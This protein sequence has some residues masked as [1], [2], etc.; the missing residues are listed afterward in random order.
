MKRL[1]AAAV[2]IALVGSAG[3]AWAAEPLVDVAWVKANLGKPNIVL[4]DLRWP[5]S[6]AEYLR[7]H[8]PGAV[9][10]DYAKDG[11]RTKDKNGTIAMLPEPAALEK[12]IGG[13]GI[14]NNTRIVLVPKGGNSLDVGAATR[15]YWTFKVLGHDNVSILDGGWLAWAVEDEK[16]KNPIN[17]MEG[18]NIEPKAKT[19]KANVRTDM[20]P[21]K[22]DVKKALATKTLLV[23]NRPN[24]Y[25]IGVTHHPDT[26]QP[27]TIPGAKNLPEAWLTKD[28]RG[29]FRTKAEL[30]KLYAAAGVPTNGEQ[31]NFC[32]TGHW[33]SVGWFA[34]SEILGNKKAKMYDGSMVEWSADPT[35]PMEKKVDLAK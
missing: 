1:F 32:N 17:P 35:A 23:D 15:V 9:Y 27:G 7:A 30:E 5:Q 12:L 33:A 21:T 28:N 25:H 13:L 18:G 11:W 26:K 4:L 20:I 22:E 29:K 24:D 16:T 19:F 6:K 10:T 8:I 3:R 14:D 34:S 31:V 2:A